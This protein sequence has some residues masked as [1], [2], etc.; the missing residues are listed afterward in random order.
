MAQKWWNKDIMELVRE[1]LNPAQIN[2]AQSEGSTVYTDSLVTFAQAFDKLE[3]V[4][5]GSSMI[6][7]AVSGLDFDVKDKT[8]E[9]AVN[10]VKQKT[11][12][13]LL[14]YRVNPYQ[15]IQEF[16]TQ[17]YTDFILE[18]NIF[19]YY[20]GAHLYHLPAGKVEVHPDPKTFVAGYTYNGITKFKPDEIIHIKD[21]N[22]TSV[23]RG[24]S[25]LMSANRTVKTLYSMQ[26]FQDQF[27]E[28]GAI[29]GIVIETDNTLSQIAK[30]RTIQHWITRYSVKNG[31]K[32]PMILDSGLKLKSIGDTNFKDMDFDN[33]IKTHDIKILLALGVPEV[34]IY[35][36]NNAN[37]SPNL[38]L[39]YLET[40]L[41]IARK[42]TSA[43]ERFF[44]YDIEVITSN[45]SA[46]QPELKD[47]ATYHVS[48]VNGGIITPNEAREEL[49]YEK[50]TG[51]DDIRVP[52]NIA[53]SAVNPGEG[54]A[55]P[56]PTE[57][58]P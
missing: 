58:A 48:L 19:M 25:R 2:I 51:S 22:S 17:I 53:G 5:R 47:I 8:V 40:V 39:F 49:R 29:A 56:K 30:D 16:R 43:I 54:G 12:T 38:R 57:P 37:I 27:F 41:P 1:K 36:G 46:L 4:N 42:F 35:G 7:S 32:R 9:G 55:P 20:D 52:A 14:N 23:Y 6:I 34:L 10:G 44:G 33:S 11:L 3:S 50:K 21:V 31:A 15:S 28:N 13:N 26:T 24:T 18:G 45:V